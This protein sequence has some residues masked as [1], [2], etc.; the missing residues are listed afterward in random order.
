MPT[1]VYLFTV[2]ADWGTKRFPGGR[3]DGERGGGGRGVGGGGPGLKNNKKNC[4]PAQK[5]IGGVYFTLCVANN[6][7]YR[8][9]KP[10]DDKRNA[11]I[12]A[13]LDGDLIKEAH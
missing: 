3:S 13:R 6:I 8:A 11:W 4:L 10:K 12:R 9:T 5:T 7:I 1:S 2:S